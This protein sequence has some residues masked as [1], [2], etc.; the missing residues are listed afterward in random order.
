[1]DDYKIKLAAFEGPMDLLMHLIEKNKIDIYDIPIA[2]L[3]HQYMEYLDRFKEFNIEVASSFIVMAATL[4][5][6]KSRMMLP[7]QPKETLEEDDIDPRAELVRRL[8]DYKR[9][10]SVSEILMQM[11][12]MEEE[13]FTREPTD[14]PVRH[15]PPENLSLK[16]LVAAFQNV[17]KVRDEL[18]VPDAIVKPEEYNI[19]DKMEEIISLLSHADG[20]II[21]SAVFCGD[22]RAELIVTFLALLELIKLKT[23]TVTQSHAFADI[24]INAR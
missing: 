9:F 10:R 23:V 1:M 7:K 6:I 19:H 18:S 16:L 3:T 14:L 20:K 8:L 12:K 24:Y 4:L 13:Y 2:S 21:F 5:Q 17:L 11:A 15:T 22:T